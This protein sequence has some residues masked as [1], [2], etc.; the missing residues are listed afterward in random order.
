[1]QC[2]AGRRRA[3]SRS[4]AVRE[5]HGGGRGVRV[6]EPVKPGHPVPRPRERKPVVRTLTLKAGRAFPAGRGPVV[7]SPVDGVATVRL[8]GAASAATLPAE[9]PRLRLFNLEL[10]LDTT[11]IDALESVARA[12]NARRI[13]GGFDERGPT[14]EVALL[15]TCHR[16]ELFVV[17]RDPAEADRWLRWLPGDAV[18]WRLRSDREAVRHL[19]EVAAG[20]RSLA[21][22]ER[23]VRDQVRSASRKIWSRHPRPLLRELLESAA[24]TADELAPS[25]PPSRSI[26]AIA[27]TAL[28][29]RVARPFPRVVVIGAGTVGRQVT[30]CLASSARV[31]VVYRERVPDDRFLRGTGARAVRVPDLA[32]ELAV[33]D[34]VIAAA[35]SGERCLDAD[36]LPSSRSLVLIDLGVPRNIDPTVRGAPNVQLVDL[37]ELSA[38][39][40]RGPVDA[41]SDLRLEEAVDRHYR[42]FERRALESWIDALRRSTES[43]RRSE[44]ERARPFLGALTAEQEVAV[45]RLT[46]RLVARLLLPPTERLRSLPPGP[47]GERL[48]RF[49]LELFDPTTLDP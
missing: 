32:E 7:S 26:A 34:G 31:T 20:R 48:R 44:L 28:L 37:G 40:D 19:F 3:S 27:A 35:K 17:A 36:D 5:N 41:D 9:P 23:E 39:R 12:V 11:S 30:E 45:D 47:D 46:R 43:L 42:E 16:V 14:E 38:H 24:A 6:G 15:V 49:A 1:M 29:E 21:V 33:A 18:S 22:G 4:G 25:V 13:D 8:T 2:R 10:S